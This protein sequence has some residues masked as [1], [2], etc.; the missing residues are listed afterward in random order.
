MES[1][2]HLIRH[3]ITEGNLKKWYYGSADI[4]LAE[5]GVEAIAENKKQGLYP[6][7]KD[8][9]FYTSGLLR[10]EQTFKLIFGEKPHKSI[11]NLQEMNFGEYECKTYDELKDV[12]GFTTWAYDLS[13]DVHFPGGDSKNSFIE[14]V[15][16]GLHE[17]LG[18]HRLKE[19]SHRHSG[20]DA[21]SIAVI[22]GG[23]M[24]QMLNELFA[25]EG[26]TL[27]DWMPEPGHGYTVY[28]QDG[29]AER[30]EKF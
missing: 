28:F 2:I 25:E 24:S 27:W 13:G 29:K 19:L 5:K 18:Y 12:E 15:S 10:T 8:A 21:V 16:K 9:D 23:V 1:Y 17:L 11:A 20:Q 30:Y 26:R 6:D 22:H 7:A 3:G 4:P 14:R